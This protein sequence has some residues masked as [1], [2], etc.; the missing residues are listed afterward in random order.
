MA[1]SPLPSAIIWISPAFWALPQACMTQASFTEMHATV[2]TPFAVRS[3]YFTTY[4]GM[5][6]FE[7]PGVNAPGTAKS[8][9]RPVP[10]SSPVCAGCGIPSSPGTVTLM[11]GTLS[12]SLIGMPEI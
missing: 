3:S 7:H 8:T 2:S 11:S 4:P 12:P 9:T 6:V 1:K 10:R 5:C